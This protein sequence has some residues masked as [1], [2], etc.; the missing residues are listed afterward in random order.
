MIVFSLIRVYSCQIIQNASECARECEKRATLIWNAGQAE[1]NMDS[2]P[3]WVEFLFQVLF[4]IG[5]LF[6][7]DTQHSS[8]P[9]RI[10]H[11]G[12]EGETQKYGSTCLLRITMSLRMS[13]K[14]WGRAGKLN[15]VFCVCM[16]FEEGQVFASLQDLT[17]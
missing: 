2:A 12:C 15:F 6:R 17:M 11:R 3:T 5:T 8:V 1:W 16:A 14:L 7:V 13:L 10:M 9:L 4:V